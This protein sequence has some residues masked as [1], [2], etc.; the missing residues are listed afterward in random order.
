MI[1]ETGRA[2][3]GKAVLVRSMHYGVVGLVIGSNGRVFDSVAETQQF[4]GISPRH[5][6]VTDA[7]FKRVYSGTASGR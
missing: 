4:R 2:A 5:T 3:D 1:A 6:I 7:V